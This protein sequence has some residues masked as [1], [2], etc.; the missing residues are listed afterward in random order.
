MC[1]LLNWLTQ[2]I[3]PSTRTSLHLIS[4]TCEAAGRGNK[5]AP[6]L[7]LVQHDTAASWSG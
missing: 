3:R 2:S 7:S 5:V 4:I 1:S 6:R